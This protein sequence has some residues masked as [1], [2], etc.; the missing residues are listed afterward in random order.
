MN[1]LTLIGGAPLSG[2]TTLSR[3]IA[4]RDGA[5]E[6]STDSIRSWMKS[7]VSPNDYPGLFY[8]DNMSAEDFYIKY[9][10]PQSVV[11][12]EIAEGMQVEKGVLALLKTAVTWDHL[13]VEGIAITPKLMTKIRDEYRDREVECIILVDENRHRIHD[14]I[15]GR[16][17][18]GPL[19]S[20]PNSLIPK[21]VEWVIL[22]NKWFH[23]QAIEYG[24]KI[25]NVEQITS[26]PVS[27]ATSI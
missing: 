2:K 1:K 26:R 27:R 11:D 7:L 15:S 5:V 10:T 9:D 3:K 6:L 19:D 17:L 20:Y 21:E 4:S 24:I 22:Y 13:V 23:E 8:S 25:L 16:G 18:W 14:R 12:G